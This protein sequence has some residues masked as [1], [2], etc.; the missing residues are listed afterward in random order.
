MNRNLFL[1][2]C[3]TTLCLVVAAP[4]NYP[5]HLSL[6]GKSIDFTV[7]SPSLELT[8][9]FI[10]SRDLN[11]KQGLDLQGGVEVL[12][13]ADMSSV[14]PLDRADALE[15]AREVIARR[16]DLYGVA[17]PVIKTIIDGDNHRISVA[18]PGVE[19]AES[20]IELIGTTAQLDFREP[21]PGTAASSIMEFVPTN[22]TGS[23]LKKSSVQFDPQDGKPVVGMTFTESGSTKFADLTGKLVGQQLAIFL[24]GYPISAPSISE[25]IVGGDAVISGDFT[26]EDAKNLAITLNAGALPVPIEILGQNNVDPT[27]GADSVRRSMRA[28]AIGLAAVALFMT[29]MYGGLGIVSV[30]GL[31]IYGLITLAVYKLV[32]ITITL[33]GLAGFILSIGMAVD[34]NI[35]IFERMKEELR[36]GREWREAME[37]GF[38]RAWDSIKDANIATMITTFILFNPLDWTFL[39]TSGMVRGFALTLFLGVVISLFTGV[40][41]TRNLLRAFTKGSTND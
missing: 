21:P 16:V 11:I 38:G 29:L 36:K 17:E 41:V 30:I 37:L 39:N 4:K 8:R 26:L 27:L 23:D 31:V 33:P 14:D 5:V 20:A 3:L 25:Q 18:L 22:L 35:L 28:G 6:F 19:N 40:F 32:P 13:G 34:S 9:P 24:D 15:S 7:S 10:F 2:V 1:I 12:L